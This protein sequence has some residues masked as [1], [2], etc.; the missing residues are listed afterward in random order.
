MI[1]EL[2][3][4]GVFQF[5]VQSDLSVSMVIDN[6]YH[7]SSITML[8]LDT[9]FNPQVMT[10]YLDL[11]TDGTKVEFNTNQRSFTCS[12]PHSTADTQCG[13]V[14]LCGYYHP[15]LKD[16]GWYCFLSCLSISPQGVPFALSITGKGPTRLTPR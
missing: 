6:S 13:Q 16:E 15:N 4:R 10:F 2:M 7:P 8:N 5:Q 12:W 11:L 14:S 9:V 1:F 3:M